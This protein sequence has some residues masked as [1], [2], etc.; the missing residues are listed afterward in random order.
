MTNECAV[1]HLMSLIL[2]N[3]NP[4]SAWIIYSSTTLGQGIVPHPQTER[5]TLALERLLVCRLAN[6][7]CANCNW[8]WIMHIFMNLKANGDTLCTCHCNLITINCLSISN[9]IITSLLWLDTVFL[10]VSLVLLS[11]W[12]SKVSE[13]TQNEVKQ[14]NNNRLTQL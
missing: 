9:I 12:V 10:I 13:G 11:L 1:E 8:S 6:I 2:L 4:S 3:N 5:W 14:L 7:I